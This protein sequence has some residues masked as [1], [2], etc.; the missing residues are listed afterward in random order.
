[1]RWHQNRL[2]CNTTL[3]CESARIC[4]VQ[5]WWTQTHRCIS[6]AYSK[7]ERARIDR[8]TRPELSTR[9]QRRRDTSRYAHI[10]M[11]TRNLNTK[12]PND[13][14]LKL[15]QT[16]QH[17]TQT[18]NLKYYTRNIN[19]KYYSDN[20]HNTQTNTLKL[21]KT[22]QEQPSNKHL[23]FAGPLSLVHQSTRRRKC[24]KLVILETLPASPRP[25]R[26]PYLPRLP[27]PPSLPRMPRLASPRP[28]RLPRLP[29]PPRLTRLA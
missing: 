15:V 9:I 25:P 5:A 2:L 21:A 27:R 24:A 29:R 16:Q 23:E 17:N 6:L 4:E 11:L 18:N 3:F 14:D 7:R 12:T 10:V 28:P 8:T 1:M 13:K 20:Q 22:H 26:L 19:Q